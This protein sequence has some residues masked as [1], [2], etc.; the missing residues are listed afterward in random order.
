MVTLKDIAAE[1]GVSVM[2]VSRVVNKQYHKVSEANVQ[3]IQAI[4]REKGYVPNSSAR[5]LSS[6]TTR[7]IAVIVQGEEDALEYPYN[8]IM[9]GHICYC[10]QS[11]GYSP[12]LYYVADYREV[13]KR[14]RTW[15][16]EGAVF[17][18]MFDQN[19]KD[20]HEDN[21]IPLIFT[22]SYSPVRQ[23]TNI[24]LDDYK[25]GELAARY[26]IGKGHRR[27]A[28]VGTS[29]SI[30]G[31]V[32][33]RLR[34]F[35]HAIEAAG[36][37]LPERC[38]ISDMPHFERVKELCHSPQPVTAFFATADITAMSLID[39][40]KSMGM[41]V[42]EDCSVIGFDNLF[43]GAY[44]TPKLTTIGQDI[45]K[46]AQIAVDVLFRHLADK[47]SPAESIVLDVAL[48]ERES[49]C[50]LESSDQEM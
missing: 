6:K 23:V 14:L 25:G 13:T 5:S 15:N 28:F 50:A 16:V 30:S 34:G 24:G 17:L 46:K 2:T 27:M 9:V 8:A 44:T 37:E 10:V 47:N 33:H 18:G 38:I 48:V 19:M 31:V 42:P 29:T 3:R 36:L 12:I 40:L 45:R 21:R 39:G 22:D 43:F 35:K 7:L 26:L 4:I 32:R 41:R 1:A 11:K 49:V 20:I